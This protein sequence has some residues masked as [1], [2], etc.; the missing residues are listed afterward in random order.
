MQANDIWQMLSDIQFGIFLASDCYT[1]ATEEEP[2]YAGDNGRRG[3][4]LSA[5][6]YP[7]SV[8]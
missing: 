6:V 3:F 8:L 1:E 2:T 7:S 4:P 5:V